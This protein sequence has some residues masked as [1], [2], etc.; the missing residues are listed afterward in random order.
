M[1]MIH[2]TRLKPYRRYVRNLLEG[3]ALALALAG[4]P[5]VAGTPATSGAPA[6]TETDGVAKWW[7]GK[8]AS[9]DWFGVRTTLEDRGI[10]FSG[11][12]K[13]AFYGIV[14]GGLDQ[15]GAFDEEINLK[16]K[17]DLEKMAGVTGLS[18]Y[19]AVRWRDGENPNYYVGASP[20]F[21]P[22]HLQVGKQWRLMPF[23]AMWESRDLLPV[24]DMVTISG[25][26]TNPYYFFI[27]QP[28]SKLFVNNAIQQTKGLT[29]SGFPWSGAYNTWGGHLKVK[30]SDWSYAQAGLYMAVPTAAALNTGNHGLYFEGAFPQDSN[31]LYFI[32]ETGVTPKIGGLPGKL[33]FGGI[34]FGVENKSFFKEAYDG[35]YSLYFQ[36]DQML[37]REP[38]PDPAPL[39][40]GPSDGKDLVSEKS[41]KEPVTPAAKPSEQGL[42]FFS[43]FD[44]SP[45]YDNAMPFYFH[46]GLVYKGL[47]P[48]RDTDQLGIAFAYGNY[49]Y[50]KILAEEDAG[51][52]IHQTYEAVLEVDYR[53]Q[54]TK[55]V[56]AQPFF[57]YIIRPSGTGMVENASILG[58]QFGVTF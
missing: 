55:F 16:L 11:D 48:T 30:P 35:R 38:S 22:S 24:K 36:A 34:Y 13:G 21:N 53:A 51:K 5:A 26:W 42:Y 4:S 1:S 23:Y 39:G 40:K 54:I 9:G 2:H 25:G 33:A 19:G 18:L 32:S 6:S 45:K 27:Q 44:Y 17:L 52:S 47:I 7:N 46:T 10:V 14:D 31:G 37:Y 50:Y 58:A 57:Q 28:E 20:A 49:S 3:G 12:W 8:Y 56:Y 43:F 41:F 29:N 15:R